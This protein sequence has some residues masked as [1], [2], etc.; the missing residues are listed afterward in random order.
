VAVFRID[1]QCP[2]CGAP[3]D[4]EETERLFACPFCRVKSFL[5]S[6]G[7]FQYVLPARNPADEALVYLPYWRFKG[8]SIFCRPDGVGHRF[9]DVSHRAV[10][11]AGVPVTLGLRAQALKLKFVSPDMAGRFIQPAVTFQETLVEFD[12]RIARSGPGSI[13]A[14]AHLGE[15]VSLLYAPFSIRNKL[16][17][18]VL[19][20]VVGAVP[21]ELGADGLKTGSPDWR[22]RFVAALCPA[23]GRDL[24]GAK[25]A[26][27]LICRSCDS[28]WYPR[29]DRLQRVACGCLAEP[30]EAATHFPFWQ[31]CADVT[32]TDLGN[33]ADLARLA[34][35]PRRIAP[36][37]AGKPFRF[38]APAFKIRAQNFLRLSESLTLTQAQE[39][40]APGTP[41]GAHH[42][43]T[44]AA[45]EVCECLKVILAGFLKP[46][47]RL[48]ELLPPIS[49][50]PRSFS[51]AYL[52]FVAD[53]HDF[54]QT[55]TRLAI[56]RNLL[57]LSG[58]L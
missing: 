53:Q 25:D 46:R 5:L 49:I 58:N 56:N 41:A 12:R 11:A 2:Q 31:V 13:L 47:H 20:S 7:G 37:A 26:L 14:G 6:R 38:W 3:A 19:N 16:Y 55:R 33:Q 52:P 8:V 54:I 17:D 15:S 43:V 22:V 32:G 48:A 29:G 1:H 35:L 27:V 28:A 40:L 44:L 21:A 30:T 34:N 23:C 18:A 36:D 4:L 24:E 39:A 10:E 9:V 50:R 51:L 57:A 42:P 45:E